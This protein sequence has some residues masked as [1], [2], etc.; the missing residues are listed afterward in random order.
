M[1]P[2]ISMTH[3][4]GFV[5]IIG[6]PNTGK[7][8]LMN[9]LTGEKLCIITAKAQTTRHRII[10]ILNGED[11]QVVLSD[12]PGLLEPRYKL[13]ESMQNAALS[14]FQDADIMIYMTEAGAPIERSQKYI[15]MLQKLDIPV[16]VLVNKI[17]LCDSEKVKQAFLQW[18]EALPKADIVSLSALHKFNIAPLREKIIALLPEGAPFFPKDQISDRSTRFFVEEIIREKILLFYKKEIPYAVQVETERYEETEK[19]VKISAIVYVERDSQKG[20]LIGDKGKALK[21]V[22]VHA[23][24]DIEAFIGRHVFLEM[25]VK[26]SKDWRNQADRLRAFGYEQ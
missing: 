24:R 7:S 18:E 20:I 10:G 4:S 16:L 8:T 23:R 13:Q 2:Q 15:S 3:K 12:T 25:F 17:D 9:A 11:Y 19:L 22:G 21:N 1:K 26:V 14:A 5:N 6:F